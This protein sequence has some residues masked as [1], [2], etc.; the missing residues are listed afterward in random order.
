MESLDD[1]LNHEKFED[2]GENSTYLQIQVGPCFAGKVFL[3]AKECVESLLN[4]DMIN[5]YLFIDI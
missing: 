5:T 4:F 1:I 2:I 3:F